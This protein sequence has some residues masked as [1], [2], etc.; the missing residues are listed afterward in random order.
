MNK[1]KQQGR[2]NCVFYCWFHSSKKNFPCFIIY[3]NEFN[4]YLIDF[5]I[6]NHLKIAMIPIQ[7]FYVV[8]ICFLIYIFN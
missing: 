7:I 8:Y 1:L 3:A 6:L 2:L 4:N 5:D